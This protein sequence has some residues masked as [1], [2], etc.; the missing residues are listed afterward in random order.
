MQKL[1][2]KILSNRKVGSEDT[3]ILKLIIVNKCFRSLC[4][5]NNDS[6]VRTVNFATSKNVNAKS[7]IFP[8]HNIYKYI[9]TFPMGKHNQI[10]HILID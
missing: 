4:E 3:R 8:N 2:A 9:W 1:G 7:T 5:T 10:F 6:G